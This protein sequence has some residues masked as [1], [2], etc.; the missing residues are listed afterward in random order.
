MAVT[1]TTDTKKVK[2]EKQLHPSVVLDSGSA[3]DRLAQKVES[4][5]V[6]IT[7]AAGQQQTAVFTQNATV[8]HNLGPV[9]LYGTLMA[10]YISCEQAPAG[11]TLS[12]ALVAYDKSG[13]AEVTLTSTVN[14]EA[15]TV[16]AGTAF[17]LAT[18]NVALDPDDTIELH[19]VADNNAIG[20]PAQGVSVTL[21]WNPTPT[22]GNVSTKTTY[23]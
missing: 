3:S 9:G 19:C 21:V 11:G 14:P 6:V 10:A 15:L 17:T 2:F 20:T 18:T 13:T 16:R 8:K 5:R 1:V 4:R 12:V 23:S 22:T 7:T